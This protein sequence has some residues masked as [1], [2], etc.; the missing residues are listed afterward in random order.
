[1]AAVPVAI[2]P[3]PFTMTGVVYYTFFIGDV[4]TIP[5]FVAGMTAYVLLNGSGLLKA[6]ADRQNLVTEAAAVNPVANC[7]V[8]E[9]AAHK[10]SE[11]FQDD[12]KD[13]NAAV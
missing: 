6:M 13:A 5:I 10:M 2:V 3:M 8:E 7:G 12:A 9:G 1:M 11:P 4:E